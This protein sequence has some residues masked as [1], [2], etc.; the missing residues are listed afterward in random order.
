MLN[1]KLK[2]KKHKKVRKEAQPIYLK[3]ERELEMILFIDFFIFQIK[4]NGKIF[5]IKS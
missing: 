5:Q 4:F 3:I 2:N 1:Q